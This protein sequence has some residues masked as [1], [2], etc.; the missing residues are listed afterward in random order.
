MSLPTI[1]KTSVSVV[2]QVVAIAIALTV[3]THAQDDIRRKQYLDE[4]RSIIAPT[5]LD[6]SIGRI[7]AMDK[8]WEDW[9]ARTGELPPDFDSMPSFADLPD[10]LILG[11]KPGQGQ[12]GSVPITTPEQWQ[13]QRAWIRSQFE[14]WVFGR[15]PPPPDNL[16]SSV[17][18]EQREAGI[19]TRKVL[20]EF[21]PG[22]RARLHV[23]LLIPEGNGPF[24]VF[25]TNQRRSGG[26]CHTAVRRGYVACIYNATDPK[27]GDPDD[28][29]DYIEIWPEYD[30][31]GLARWAFSAMRAV[32]YLHTLPEVNKDQIGITG[33]S[34]NGKQALLA[35]A[36]DERIGAVVA[37]SGNVG[38]CLPWRFPPD[39]FLYNALEAIT[40]RAHNSYWFHPR[41]RFFA[42]REHKLPVD[43]HMLI[44]LV[45]PRGVMMYSAYAEVEGNPWGFEQSYRS[46]QRVYRFL[47]K[48]DH[49]WLHLRAGEHSTSA[50]DIE[51]FMDFFDTVF[52]RKK[53]AKSETWINGYTF[54]DWLAVSQ[55]RIDPLQFPIRT[56]GEQTVTSEH[57]RANIAWALGPE[58]SHAAVTHR[59][60]IAELP[61]PDDHELALLYKRPFKVTGA[62]SY[63]LPYGD[64]LKAELYFP[65]GADG[66]PKPGPVPAVVWLHAES[67][68]TGY[69]RQ[70]ASPIA[71]LTRR[72]IAVVVF[73]QIGF[74]TRMH[75]AREFY[76]RYPKWSLMGKMVTDTRGVVEAMS[77]LDEIDPSRIGLVG[78]AMGGNVAI[79]TAASS[80]K[81]KL[82][83]SVGGFPILRLQS[84]DKGTEGIRHYSHLHGLI[85][86]L[87]FFVGHER[88]LP[89]DF[90]DVLGLVAPKPAMI[91]APTLDRHMSVADVQQGIHAARTYYRAHGSEDK[92]KLESPTEIGR[93]TTPIQSLV[94]DWLEKN[95]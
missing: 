16:R 19:T 38:E 8:T 51:N 33:H 10:P 93:F 13:Q 18:S 57:V 30:F 35:A 69:G 29:N 31:S 3:P 94:F 24:P 90:D 75:S 32:D 83:A 36:F 4:L 66:K 6:P 63:A 72:G 95:L 46:A 60:K 56:I 74:G 87:G 64:G 45:A 65:V 17:L 2:A 5:V 92:L 55:E 79:L 22:H 43:Q 80:E 89:L 34:R 25:L 27:Y 21:G 42:G 39:P 81:V 71:A 61:P 20:L 41:L 53:F 37:S 73:D 67:Y 70:A 1:L 11:G 15:M 23:E 82:C 7:S 40:A 48:D 59:R 68:A 14:Q 62:V 50:A 86:R 12:D 77:A 78:Y 84:T 49:L 88:R 76:L 28:S 91:V 44:S 26:W 85:P 58:P 47:K 52:K 9:V 54:D